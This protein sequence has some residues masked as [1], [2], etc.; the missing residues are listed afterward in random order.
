M[1]STTPLP[2]R[3]KPATSD[4]VGTAILAVVGAIALVMGL[5]YG[6]RGDSGQVGPGFLP[7]AT[8][9]FILVASLVEIGRLYLTAG[10]KSPE[11][12]LEASPALAKAEERD[13]FGRVEG[14]RKQA[15]IRIFGIML[16]SL[17]IVPIVG[18]L[19]ALALMVFVIV[20]WVESKTVLAA[21]LASA[22]ATAVAYIVFVQLLG[23][24]TPQ[25]M[26][27]VL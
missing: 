1:S 27:G 15:I 19:L 7:V 9:T 3:Q 13:T 5:G 21:F 11:P 4:V 10:R 23:V 24:P 20:L 17:L 2:Q 25:G 26:L 14:E 22:G 12:E 16:V 8:G 6:F 18:L